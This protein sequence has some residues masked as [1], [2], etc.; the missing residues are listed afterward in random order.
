[1]SIVLA[2]I[3]AM[4]GLGDQLKTSTDIISDCDKSQMLFVLE[5]SDIPVHDLILSNIKKLELRRGMR[6]LLD[7]MEESVS[8]WGG[9]VRGNPRRDI[10]SSGMRASQGVIS[11]EREGI[12][13]KVERYYFLEASML[14]LHCGQNIVYIL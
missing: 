14:N 11:I 12:Y 3:L 10:F 2:E 6:I 13:K 5:V 7:S 9:D 8:L 1:M 4:I